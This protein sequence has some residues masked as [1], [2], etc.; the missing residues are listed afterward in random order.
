VRN[1]VDHGIETS[2]DRISLGKQRY[3][4]IV[5]EA[6]TIENQIRITVTDDGR[7]IHPEQ[8]ASIFNVGFST[9]PEV[10]A[11]SGR[12]VGLDVVKTRVEEAGGSVS[13][14]S[15]LGRGSAFEMTFPSSSNPR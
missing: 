1:A 8:I 7:G 5:I 2:D 4:K 3:G 11:I 13:V 15:Q 14:S 6:T 10:S 9:A 12:G